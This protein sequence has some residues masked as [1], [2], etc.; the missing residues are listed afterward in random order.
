MIRPAHF[1]LLQLHRPCPSPQVESAHSKSL[2]T[3]E[4]ITDILYDRHAQQ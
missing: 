3:I 1:L 2:S 4:V